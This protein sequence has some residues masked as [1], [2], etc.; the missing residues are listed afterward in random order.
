MAG[1]GDGGAALRD[2][3]K[4]AKGRAVVCSLLTT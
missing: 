3:V 1:D 4:T 2:F